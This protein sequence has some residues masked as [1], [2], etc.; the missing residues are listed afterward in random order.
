MAP[1]TK[2]KWKAMPAELVLASSRKKQ[3]I[4]LESVIFLRAG[5]ETVSSAA[6]L[7]GAKEL[8]VME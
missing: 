3:R 5:N 6:G 8:A 1:E 4:S 7:P 2:V